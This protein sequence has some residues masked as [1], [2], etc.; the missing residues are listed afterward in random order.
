MSLDT[1]KESDP[2]EVWKE[3]SVHLADDRDYN[4]MQGEGARPGGTFRGPVGV[5]PSNEATVA[6]RG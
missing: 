2:H 3:G 5:Y 1:E 4:S 6:A